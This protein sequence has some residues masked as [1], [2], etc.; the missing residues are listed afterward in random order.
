MIKIYWKQ[1][2]PMI[3][4]SFF[5]DTYLCILIIDILVWTSIRKC[6]LTGQLWETPLQWLY[7]VD[8]HQRV[9]MIYNF[10]LN[11]S[12]LLIFL[13]M[14]QFKCKD[15]FS[16]KM[17]ISFLFSKNTFLYFFCFGSY[18]RNIYYHKLMGFKIRILLF[19]CHTF[20]LR[21]V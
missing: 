5:H 3:S 2:L 9:K 17:N 19:C 6:A 4:K 16:K 1:I 10:N 8:I 12:S 18:Y 15:V 7:W 13:S 14:I 11:L 21:F 20:I